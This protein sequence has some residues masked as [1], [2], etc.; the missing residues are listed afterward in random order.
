MHP[1]QATALFTATAGATML[2]H[3]DAAVQKKSYRLLRRLVEAGKLG[4]ALAGD[5]IERFVES[6]NEVA[7]GVGPGAQRVSA[8]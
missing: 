5:K 7:A 2:E 3:A 4:D 8:Q 1:S 6:L